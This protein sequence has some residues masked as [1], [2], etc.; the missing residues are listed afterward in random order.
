MRT[1]MMA[2]CLAFLPP[3]VGP[4]VASEGD[5]LTLSFLG[6][7]YVHRWSEGDQHEF[8]PNGQEDLSS[9]TDMLTLTVFPEVW[10]G[11]ELAAVANNVRAL[12][13]DRGQILKTD[14]VRRRPWKPREEYFV[15]AIL[16]APGLIELVFTR[17][18]LF[19]DT[20]LAIVASHRIYGAESVDI[21]NAWI[22]ANGAGWEKALLSWRSI[23]S[24]D[25]LG[26]PPDEAT[27]VMMSLSTH[28]RIVRNSPP[29][30]KSKPWPKPDVSKLEG[31]SRKELRKGLGEPTTCS[32]AAAPTVSLPACDEADRWAFSFYRLVPGSR[33]GGLELVLEF[34]PG[35]TAISSDLLRTQ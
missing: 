4:A 7:Q 30:I 3:L 26:D 11:E 13:R 32:T 25:S 14:A 18:M 17:I 34:S 19:D 15:N 27:S 23:P 2:M 5:Q 31:L 12:Y 10:D 29:P 22:E 20:G 1:T 21:V 6:Q 28:L 16:P 9:W 24:L 35:G 33:G 8:T